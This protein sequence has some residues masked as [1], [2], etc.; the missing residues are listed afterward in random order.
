MKQLFWIH[1]H[2]WPNGALWAPDVPFAH[3]KR[4]RHCC[5]KMALPGVSLVPLRTL[6][7]FARYV[8]KGGRTASCWSREMR[9]Y[10]TKFRSLQEH[11]SANIQRERGEWTEWLA[12]LANMTASPP[13]PLKDTHHLAVPYKRSLKELFSHTVWLFGGWQ[14]TPLIVLFIL[15]RRHKSGPP[16]RVSR[17]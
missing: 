14:N 10:G 2:Y 15:S 3:Y 12:K 1:L 9:W 11:T 13:Q 5:L 6:C 7:N 17:P 16:E 4:R 8:Q